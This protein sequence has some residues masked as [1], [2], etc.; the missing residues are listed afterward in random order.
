MSVHVL[1]RD[2]YLVPGTRTSR[3]PIG[4]HRG[5]RAE[6]MRYRYPHPPSP[7]P[8]GRALVQVLDELPPPF[9]DHRNLSQQFHHLAFLHIPISRTG[10]VQW[11]DFLLALARWYAPRL[12]HPP[13]PRPTA[14]PVG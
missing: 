12:T 11:K 14:A 1:D 10:M 8:P 4:P 13:G 6:R 9:T 2:R 3:D 5:A 7:Q